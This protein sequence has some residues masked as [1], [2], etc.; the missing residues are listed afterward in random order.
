M[1]YTSVVNIE[2]EM[3]KNTGLHTLRLGGVF[4][5]E[6]SSLEKAVRAAEEMVDGRN[7]LAVV[8]IIG[9]TIA[10]ETSKDNVSIVYAEDCRGKMNV[11]V[12]EDGVSI[13]LNGSSFD[14]PY[15]DKKLSKIY[16]T[17][18]ALAEIVGIENATVEVKC[19]IIKRTSMKLETFKE[20]VGI[21]E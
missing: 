20:L 2:I 15:S 3:S 21:L 7:T 12:T 10:V 13:N 9:T 1:P 6:Y 16:E 5:D 11:T 14:L 18:E 19:G 4:I 17:L 8:T